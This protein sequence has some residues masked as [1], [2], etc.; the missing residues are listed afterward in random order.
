[1]AFPSDVPHLQFYTRKTALKSSIR[2][3]EWHA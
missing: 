2:P 3:H 1:V